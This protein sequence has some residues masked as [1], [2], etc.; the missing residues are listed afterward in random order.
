MGQLFLL[1]TEFLVFA[2]A[3][4]GIGNIAKCVLDSLLIEECGFLSASLSEPDAA[5]YPAPLE[6]RLDGISAKAPK[7]CGPG[8]QTGQSRALITAACGQRN[9]RQAVSLR[10]ANLSVRRDQLRFRLKNA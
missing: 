6:H 8:E 2:V 10:D 4:E 1:D 7:P 9:L 3:N 5:S